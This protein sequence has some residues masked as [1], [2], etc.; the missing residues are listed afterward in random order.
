MSLRDA[1][2]PSSPPPAVPAVAGQSAGPGAPPPDKAQRDLSKFP[3]HSQYLIAL[4]M[5]AKMVYGPKQRDHLLKALQASGKPVPM[6]VKIAAD[7]GHDLDQRLN[8]DD[9]IVLSVAQEILAMVLDLAEEAGMVQMTPE[10]FQKAVQGVIGLMGKTYGASETD[11]ANVLQQGDPQG[12][13]DASAEPAPGDEAAEAQS[14]PA[15]QP[16]M[17]AP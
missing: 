10:L 5:A 12:A 7:L 6:A 4:A 2:Q 9:P 3:T 1:M 14:Q 15:Q 17:G 11:L 16:P 13:D 8:L